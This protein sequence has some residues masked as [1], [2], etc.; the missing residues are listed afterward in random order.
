MLRLY[1]ETDLL[2]IAEDDAVAAECYGCMATI[3]LP[4]LPSSAVVDGGSVLQDYLYHHYHIE[5]PVKTIADQLYVR[6]SCHIYNI[7]QDYLILA[8][9]ITEIQT[10]TQTEEA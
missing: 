8:A 5:C 9:A 6:I 1:W 4:A 3:R 10:Q 2:T 7:P